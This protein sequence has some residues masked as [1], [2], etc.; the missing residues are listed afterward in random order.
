MF[1]PYLSFM[2]VVSTDESICPWFWLHRWYFCVTLVYAWLWSCWSCLIQWRSRGTW[3]IS[4]SSVVKI[5]CNGRLCFLVDVWSTFIF[6]ESMKRHVVGADWT[7]SAYVSILMGSK[8]SI[9]F[10][11]EGVDYACSM[12]SEVTISPWFSAALCLLLNSLNNWLNDAIWYWP[13]LRKQI[14]SIFW[15]VLGIEAVTC[16]RS[17]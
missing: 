8:N 14:V 17:V 5:Y 3:L 4:R 13:A 6:V 1:G 7:T 11:I 15:C 16:L 12:K 10:E 2:H 9:V